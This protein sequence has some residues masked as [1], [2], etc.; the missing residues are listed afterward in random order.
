MLT[1]FIKTFGCQMN[2]SDSERIA[3][4]L[5]SINFQPTQNISTADLIIVNACSVRQSAIDRIYGL[6]AKWLK[7]KQNNNFKT[8]LTGCLLDLDK[9]K[10]KPRFDLILDIRDLNT[11][12]PAIANLF[13]DN[14]LCHTNYNLQTTNYLGVKP[15]YSNS[16]T[17]LVPIMNGCNNFCS[18]CVVPYTRHRETSRP[19]DEIIKEVK[20]LIKRGYKEIILIGQNVNSYQCPHS[21]INFPEL[22]RMINNLSGNFWLNFVTSHPKDMSDELIQTMAQS[23]KICPYVH[24]PVQSG[25]NKILQAMN[26]HYTVQHYKKLIKKIKHN[27]KKYRI[28]LEKYPAISTDII[29]GFPGETLKQFKHT[30]RLAKKIKYDMI[31]VGQY[32]PRPQTTA[33]KLKDDVSKTEKK[34]RDKILNQILQKTNLKNNQRFV[35]QTLEVLVDKCNNQACFGHTRHF[36]NVKFDSKN[37]LTGHKIKVKIKQAHDWNLLGELIS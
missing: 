1:Y 8:I 14:N 7:Q 4:L 11:W 35:N 33:A 5:N 18:Y 9:K 19:A 3:G 27:F 32:S 28:G 15:N 22:L 37:D 13:S 23:L 2:I 34:N 25:D 29:V 12:P 30:L 17:A 31:Y 20:S 10:L 16:H 21:Q 26:R 24:L 36:K 6:S